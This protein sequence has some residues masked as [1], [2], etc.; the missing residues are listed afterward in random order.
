MMS[1]V[2][3]FTIGLTKKT[4]E[5][6]F[7]RLSLSRFNLARTTIIRKS[8]RCTELTYIYD[9]IKTLPT[10]PIIFTPESYRLGPPGCGPRPRVFS[11]SATSLR[12]S[13]PGAQDALGEVPLLTVA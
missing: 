5:E 11:R 3:I 1:K 2:R 7:T 13:Y 9:I 6:F 10:D 8:V 4:A 12:N